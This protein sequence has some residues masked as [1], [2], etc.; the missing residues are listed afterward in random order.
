MRDTR[1]AYPATGSLPRFKN[2]RSKLI[3]RA[4]RPASSFSLRDFRSARSART[5][6][7]TA[8]AAARTT[9]LGAG[10]G[11]EHRLRLHRQQA[12]ALQLLA[13]QL[14]GAAH[15]LR[16]FSGPPLRARFLI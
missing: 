8:A 5:C 1:A 12:F 14:A 2:H 9:A 4:P 16:P 7:G 13:G 10:T 6:A 11:A 15:G 3:T